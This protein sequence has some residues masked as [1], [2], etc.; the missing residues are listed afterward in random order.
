MPARRPALGYALVAAAASLWALNGNL[1]RYLLD[2]GV[3]ALRLAQLRST[4]A[5]LVLLALILF[6]RPALLRVERRQLPALAVL[7][8]A[9]LALVHATYFLSIERLQIGVAITIQYLAPLLLLLW[10]GVVHRRRLAP[11]LW[12][13]VGL[14]VVG[15]F[16]VVRAY[17]AGALDGLGL[18]FAL[19][20]AVSFAV[21][22]VAAERAGHQHEPATTLVWGFGFATLFWAVVTPWWDFPF[23]DFDS[24]RHQALAAG[25]IVAGTL[26]PFGCMVAALRHVP[27]SRALPAST[28]EPVIAAVLAWFLHDEV[29]AAPQLAGAVLVLTAVAWVQSRR[30]DLEAEAAPVWGRR[31]EG[32]RA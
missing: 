23:G 27:A 17:D 9:G 7:G 2:D 29:L 8:V 22:M 26:L 18:V 28:L 11:G 25:V 13:A 5:W 14:S 30:P 1:A 15:C 10:L 21:W 3:S 24:F 19:A 6:S 16:L 31:T 4:A 12:G 20:A 32:G